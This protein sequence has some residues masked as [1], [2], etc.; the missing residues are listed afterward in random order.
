MKVLYWLAAVYLLALGASVRAQTS[1]GSATG[2]FLISKETALE[3]ELLESQ[4]KEALKPFEG[5]IIDLR[6][7]ADKV[8]ALAD[9]AAAPLA[10]RHN[11]LV[12]EACK[13]DGISEA[14]TKAGKCQVDVKAR[15]V[16][17]APEPPAAK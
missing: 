12:I 16:K 14:D 6:A 1:S 13:A 10:T 5:I 8:K 7:A 9:A 2:V 17:R 15:T 11:E 4:Q 3:L